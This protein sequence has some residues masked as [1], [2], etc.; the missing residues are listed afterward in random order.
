MREKV[1]QVEYDE[2][3]HHLVRPYNSSNVSKRLDLNDLLK[4]AKDQE[5][6]D[7]KLNL[8]ISKR[9]LSLYFFFIK[10]NKEFLKR[11]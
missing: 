9:V 7:R 3:E 5:K 8:L 1:S 4:R 2:E 10:E 11:F 6:N